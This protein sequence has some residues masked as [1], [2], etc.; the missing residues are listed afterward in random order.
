MTN[1]DL[2]ARIRAYMAEHGVNYTTARRAITSKASKAAEA[3]SPQTLEAMAFLQ[4]KAPAPPVAL[5]DAERTV[6]YEILHFGGI[7]VSAFYKRDRESAGL[8]RLYK[9]GLIDLAKSG[10]SREGGRSPLEGPRFDFTNETTCTTALRMLANQFGTRAAAQLLTL[11][12]PALSTWGIDEVPTGLLLAALVWHYEPA[13]N[14]LGDNDLPTPPPPTV[15][16]IT[17]TPH[18]TDASSALTLTEHLTD[19]TS[20]VRSIHQA[21]W[22]DGDALARE[23]PIPGSRGYWDE[24]RDHYTE[25]AHAYLLAAVYTRAAKSKRSAE[26]GDITIDLATWAVRTVGQPHHENFSDTAPIL[27][28]QAMHLL[29][30]PALNTAHAFI[31]WAET[32]LTATTRCGGTL[33]SPSSPWDYKPKRSNTKRHTVLINPHDLTSTTKHTTNHDV[34]RAH[35][36]FLD[37]YGLA[38]THRYGCQQTADAIRRV[39]D[40]DILWRNA[41]LSRGPAERLAAIRTVTRAVQFLDEGLALQETSYLLNTGITGKQARKV[42]QAVTDGHITKEDALRGLAADGIEFISAPAT[43]ENANVL[44]ARMLDPHHNH[45]T[46]EFGIEL[47]KMMKVFNRVSNVA[48][49][50]D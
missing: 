35:A 14:F 36:E 15:T 9:R 33:T 50:E 37:T 20:Q 31:E 13:P 47:N 30:A 2:K 49:P 44:I 27:L 42:H 23:T 38:A 3:A 17:I 4:R 24:S 7:P 29:D 46:D 21:T 5:S 34:S 41:K 6:I 19:G 8:T 32:S 10:P 11:R 28:Q 1:T 43:T 18:A 45:E 39:G 25:S 16:R 12:M 40:L 48:F 26:W 22:G